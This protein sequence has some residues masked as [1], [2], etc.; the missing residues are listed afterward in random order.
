MTYLPPSNKR[1]D[2]AYPKGKA[3]DRAKK[4]LK[5]FAFYIPMKVHT[6]TMYNWLLYDTKVLTDEIYLQL[7]VHIPCLMVFHQRTEY[8]EAL[9]E[10]M[11]KN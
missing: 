4:A 5:H 7:C 8:C 2:L 9:E 10:K 6:A 3:K 11:E 1:V